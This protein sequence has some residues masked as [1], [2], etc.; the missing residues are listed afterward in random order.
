MSV[1]YEQYPHK[2]FGTDLGR[3]RFRSIF[4]CA[5]KNYIRFLTQFLKKKRKCRNV[6]IYELHEII[7]RIGPLSERVMAD[8]IASRVNTFIK[9]RR[10]SNVL[11]LNG[12]IVEIIQFIKRAI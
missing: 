7:C 8:I 3:L 11:I 1:I 6:R 10:K 9:F 2:Y 5:E 12:F 4:Y